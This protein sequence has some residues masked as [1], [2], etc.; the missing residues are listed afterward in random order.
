MLNKIL[1]PRPSYMPK[2]W[3]VPSDCVL[4][5][6]GQTDGESATVKD[7]SGLGYHGTKDTI[8]NSR[9]DGGLNTWSFD[10]ANSW[11]GA[12]VANWRS[13]DSAGS[14]VAW[15]KPTAVANA[16]TIFA[17]CDTLGN[18][19]KF[20]FDIY[21]STLRILQKNND[22]QD[23]CAT[24]EAPTAGVWQLV[25]LTSSGTAWQIYRNKTALTM[26]VGG[27]S[28]S[29]DWFAETIN[30]DVWSVGIRKQNVEDE[31][32]LGSMALVRV[33]SSALSPTQING[34]YDRERHLFG[35]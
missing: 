3:P 28:N 22:V 26:N 31:A 34:I 8:T 12:T 2:Y 19:Y 25:T 11:I 27:G 17:S 1:I 6:E 13:T 20:W 32:F 10:G 15:I 9:T 30:R 23:Y 24:T 5:L 35:V 18:S 7:L 33:Y 21:D 4:Y 16:Q 29:G 14:I